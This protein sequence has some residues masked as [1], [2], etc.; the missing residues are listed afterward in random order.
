MLALESAIG[1]SLIGGFRNGI[2]AVVGLHLEEGILLDVDALTRE[3]P[4]A[5]DPWAEAYADEDG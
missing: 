4:E 2:A 5:A 3:V 1:A